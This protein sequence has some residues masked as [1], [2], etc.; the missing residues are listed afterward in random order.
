MATYALTGFDFSTTPLC[1]GTYKRERE[2]FFLRQ[3]I[4]D[5]DRF[6]GKGLRVPIGNRVAHASDALPSVWL[7]EKTDA[8]DA[9][10]SE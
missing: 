10:V 5:K 7:S 3:G 2:V 6:G 9:I 4:E 8:E 1:T